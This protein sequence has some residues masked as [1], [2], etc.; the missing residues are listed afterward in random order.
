MQPVRQEKQFN[1]KISDAVETDA[2]N[3]LLRRGVGQTF[4][5]FHVLSRTPALSLVGL[6]GVLPAL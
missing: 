5:S 3:M 1:F 4:S 6:R 2:S